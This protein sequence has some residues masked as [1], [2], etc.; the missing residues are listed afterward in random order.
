MRSFQN[1]F[2]YWFTP[3][4]YVHCWGG[5]GSQLFALAVV[6]QVLIEKPNRRVALVLHTSGV[7]QRTSELSSLAQFVKIVQVSDFKSDEFSPNSA[8]KV[9]LKSYIRKFALFVLSKLRFIINHEDIEKMKPWTFQLRSHYSRRFISPYV[10]M[11]MFNRLVGIKLLE[12]S[13]KDVEIVLGIHY[14]LGDLLTLENKNFISPE[15][16]LAAIDELISQNKLDDFLIKIHSDS[17]KVANQK[18]SVL[19]DD[20]VVE[21]SESNPWGTLSALVQHDYLVVTNSKIGIWAIVF[22]VRLRLPHI[23]LA[24]CDMK[25]DL[26]LILGEDIKFLRIEYY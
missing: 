11:S 22:K 7:T 1:K 21:L 8:R 17:P 5:L 4:L 23:V 18:L 14:R 15:R 2:F 25:P 6:E 12:K 10:C 3:T 16:L 13:S 20:F 24:P 9:G 19:R 26:A